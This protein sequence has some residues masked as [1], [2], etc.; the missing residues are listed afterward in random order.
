MRARILCLLCISIIIV[1]NLKLTPAHFGLANAQQQNN[2]SMQLPGTQS[3][4]TTTNATN[5][6]IVLVHGTWVDGSSWSKVIPL[7]QN[8]GHK[9][10]AVQ[11][12]LHSLADD[13]ATVKRA[14]DLVG[15]PAILVGHSYGGFVITNAAYNNPN[16]KGLVYLAAFAPNE[17]QSLSNFVDVTKF[18]KGFLVVDS[19][20]FVYINPAMF[21]QAFA[22]DIDPAQ[23]KVMAATQKP[24]NQSILAEKSGP[25]AWKQLPAWYQISENDH[26]IPPDAE[27]MFAKQINATTIS[28]PS[29]HASPVSHPN[30]VAQLILNATKGGK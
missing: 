13:I 18:P 20:G 3:V 7:L 25:P 17:G 30:E 16:V 5:V 24:Y 23:A 22:Q 6:N 27:R 8:A 19:G 1:V 28:L 12:P 14:I 2:T 4:A 9:V 21:H 10:I 15:G 26:A 11:L 29:S